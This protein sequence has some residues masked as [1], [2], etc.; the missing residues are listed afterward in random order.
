MTAEII[1][2]KMVYTNTE[3]YEQIL[4]SDLAYY[5]NELCKKAIAYDK[6][7]TAPSPS[8]PQSKEPVSE[9]EMRLAILNWMLYHA[10]SQDKAVE[11]TNSLMSEITA[12]ATPA[13]ENKKGE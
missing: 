7:A 8:L 4:D 10:F 1:L 9:G 3:L 13:K 11:Y 12:A 2:T 5:F 6:S